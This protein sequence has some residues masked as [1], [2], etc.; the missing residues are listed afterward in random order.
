MSRKVRIAYNGPAL[1]NGEMDVRDLAPA[2]L[3]FADL[4]NKANTII[5]GEHAVK[6]LLNQDSIQKGS[7]DVTMLLDMN[8]LDQARLLVGVANDNGLSELLTV[9]GWGETVVGATVPVVAGIF[10]LV[11]AMA[12][13]EPTS[14]QHRDDGYVGITLANNTVIVTGESTLNLY[15]NVDARKDLE[16]VTKP[17]DGN[18]INSFELRNPDKPD[19]REAIVS[20]T[21]K[22]LPSFKSPDIVPVQE[23]TF[24]EQEMVMKIVTLALKPDYA[25]RLSDGESTFTAVIEDKEFLKKVNNRSYIFG[26]GDM[27]HVK[28][29]MK[30]SITGKGNISVE[31]TITKVIKVIPKPTQIPLPFGK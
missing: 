8:V 5:G 30:Q 18:K 2:L 17:V 13:S 26:A 27:L 19:V 4:V 15:L 3:A 14:I 11:Q 20:I 9:L 28:Y 25:W 6:V 23:E 31:R 10:Q 21:S 24:P 29:V 1:S 16:Q 12:G 22:D 7:F